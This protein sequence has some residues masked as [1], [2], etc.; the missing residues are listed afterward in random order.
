L[1]I[2]DWVIVVAYLI[3]SIL[4]G[5]LFSKRAGRSLSDYFLSG[6]SLPWWVIGSSMVATT[7]A[8][9]TPLAVTEY[10]RTDGIWRNWFWWNLAISH[11][12]AAI[13]FSRLWRRANVLTDNELLEIRYHGKKAAFLRGFKALYFSTIYNFIVMG[14]V[15]AAMST[16]LSAFMDIPIEYAIVGCIIIALFYSLLSGF[17]G[18]VVTDLIQF[19][20]AMAGAVIFA[21]IAAEHAGGMD[22]IV[23]TLTESN[24]SNL[25]IFFPTADVSDKNWY[26]FLL[27]ITVTWWSNH[28]ADGGG[29]IIQR[30]MSA[31]N[32]KHAL[33]G[34]L[35][36]AIAHYI[37]RVWPWIIVALA[38]L[39]IYP[40]LSSHKEAY[41]ML[42]S[43]ILPS[44]LKGLCV[45]S[46]LAAFMSTIDTH[47]NWGSSYVVNDIYKRFFRPKET[48][49]HYV[50]V[51]KLVSLILMSI[52]GV[53]AIFIDS[54]SGAWELVWAMGSGVGLVLILRWFWWRINAWSEISA[55]ACSILVAIGFF[56]HDYIYDVETELYIKAVYVI[57]ISIVIWLVVTFLT[58]PEPKE[59]LDSFYQRAKPPGFWGADKTK[60]NIGYWT[61][62]SWLGGVMMIYGW[63]FF[64]GSLIIGNIEMLTWTATAGILG[65]L[66]VLY[67][68]KKQA[69][70]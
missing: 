15:T 36:F 63:M 13:V 53:V 5:L 16:I 48:Q 52:A 69:V 68:L 21:V 6:R 17:W 62:F 42:L 41:P 60:S 8:A 61:L 24:K 28:N 49:K 40:T 33:F 51:S 20:M 64:V 43:S 66:F 39:V 23:S 31:K 14:W 26:M 55:L 19:C 27:F 25:M 3:I 34:T 2:L 29:Y 57:G 7:F 67:G 45:A 30:M 35:W 37:L 56:I 1:S 22:N 4:V 46:F 47:L 54:I 9:D 18:V 65:I 38:S 32:E 59:T 12:L 70:Y 10:V 50:I 11:V 58:S 44:G